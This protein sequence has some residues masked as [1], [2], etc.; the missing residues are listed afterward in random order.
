M[1][2]DFTL[3][4]LDVGGTRTGPVLFEA[5]TARQAAEFFDEF[6]RLAF[7]PGERGGTMLALEAGEPGYLIYEASSSLGVAAIHLEGVDEA[8]A[9]FFKR[10]ILER[11]SLMILFGGLEAGT[12]TLLDPRRNFFVRAG[13]FINGE[14]ITGH[15]RDVWADVRSDIAQSFA[16]IDVSGME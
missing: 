12:L 13:A 7:P 2:S 5:P 15:S 14:L 4:L 10:T 9:E 11:G 8:T 6:V 3:R 1:E 16:C